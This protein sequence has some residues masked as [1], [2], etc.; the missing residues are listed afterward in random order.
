VSQLANLFWQLEHLQTASV[1]PTIELAKLALV[2][3]RDE[4]EDEV[5]TDSSNDTDATLVEDAPTRIPTS[6]QL[7]N[8]PLRLPSSVLGKRLRDQPR[9]RSEMDVDSPCVESERDKDGFVIVSSPISPLR[10]ST[11][12]SPAEASSSKSRDAPKPGEIID[13]EMQDG[14]ASIDRVATKTAP[15]PKTAGTSDSSMMF[16]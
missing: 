12:Q 16:G 14:S 13:V 1:T 9:Q 10:S 2:T 3:S 5:G 6:D 11:P 7:R 4:E 8:S 15:P